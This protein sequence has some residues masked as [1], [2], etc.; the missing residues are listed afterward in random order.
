MTFRNFYVFYAELW[1]KI[2]ILMKMSAM[3]TLKSNLLCLQNKVSL[4]LLG[5]TDNAGLHFDEYL[6]S[7][8]KKRDF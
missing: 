4:I 3:Y 2:L 5:I 7:T 8:L 6:G 1:T